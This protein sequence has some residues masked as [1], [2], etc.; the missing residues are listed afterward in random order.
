MLGCL[1]TYINKNW[2]ELGFDFF[3]MV[4][5]T[6]DADSIVSFTVFQDLIVLI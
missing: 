2:G 3:K 5:V 1:P 4:P 6:S